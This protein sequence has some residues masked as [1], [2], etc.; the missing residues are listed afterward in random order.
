MRMRMVK[1]EFFLDE[2]LAEISPLARLFFIGLWLTADRSGRLEDRPERLR[3]QILPY[4]KKADVGKILSELAAANFIIR[5]E[6]ANLRLIQIRSFGKHQRPH[7]QEP[8]S[9]LPPVTSTESVISYKNTATS[10]KNTST[11]SKDTT[12]SPESLTES[13]TESLKTNTV[14][15]DAPSSVTFGLFWEQYPRKTKRETAWAEWKRL[16]PDKA[17]RERIGAAVLAW[18]GSDQWQRGIVPHGSTWLHQ[19]RW[20]DEIPVPT[21]QSRA[22]PDTVGKSTWKQSE[23]EREE[24]DRQTREL[25]E[26]RKRQQE[27]S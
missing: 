9:E 27:A 19:K 8:I 13:L 14:G 26:Q 23:A 5:Y 2:E 12:T 22:S 18:K 10:S 6:V 17:L 15:A 20:E 21:I 1:P 16:K 3:V 7:P 24:Y 25:I 11:S 4:D